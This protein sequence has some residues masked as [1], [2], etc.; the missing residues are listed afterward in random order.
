MWLKDSDTRGAVLR[1]CC[2]I[3]LRKLAVVVHEVVEF[4]H[5]N[6]HL[7]EGLFSAGG[8]SGSLQLLQNG[9][10]FVFKLLNFRRSQRGKVCEG[11]VPIT[12]P[13]KVPVALPT[14]TKTRAGT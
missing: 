9:I 10:E 3:S 12:I 14:T 6:T 13:T 1:L 11:P 4:C 2:G 7:Q 5:E 8:V